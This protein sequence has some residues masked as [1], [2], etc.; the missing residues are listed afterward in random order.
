MRTITPRIKHLQRWHNRTNWLFLFSAIFIIILLTGCGGGAT[1]TQASPLEEQMAQIDAILKQTISASIAYNKPSLMNLE[2]TATIEL[3]LNPS[4][5]P[6][7]LSTQIV[8]SGQVVSASIQITPRMKAVLVASDPTA[9]IIQ[10]IHDDPEQLISSTDTT[11]W[12]WLVT[13]KKSG[14]QQLTLII[15]R[16]IT[17]EGEVYWREVETYKTD[18]DVKVTLVQQ[19]E[20]FDWK[21]IAG[22]AITLIGIP[23][24]WRYI[25]NRNK[26]KKHAKS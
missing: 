11:R 22:I 13:A 25:D 5:D 26:K 10:E 8:E 23:A 20:A 24:L 7:A 16:L 9:F 15:Y 2:Q 12:S 4:L 1:A 3:L 21:W 17:Y 6:K 19:L 18:I 14:A